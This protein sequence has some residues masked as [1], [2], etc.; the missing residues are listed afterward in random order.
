VPDA[1]DNCPFVANATQADGDHDG[2]G[3]ECD[4]DADN[5]GL[6]NSDEV[7]SGTDPN[8]PDTDGDGLT[9]GAEVNTTHTDPLNPDSD[10][11]GFTDKQEVQAH[12]NPNDPSDHPP[13]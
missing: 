6:G 11:D 1:S 9:D 12:T 5:D 3:D 10:G 4:F 2:Q 8:N 7:E 13:V